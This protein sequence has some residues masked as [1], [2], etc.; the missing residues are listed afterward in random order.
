[1]GFWGEKL[2]DKCTPEFK[3]LAIAALA[4]ATGS[5]S[6]LTRPGKLWLGARTADDIETP[7]A[8][9]AEA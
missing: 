2:W 8:A 9:A 6:K 7:S 1:M 5:K 4:A 3:E